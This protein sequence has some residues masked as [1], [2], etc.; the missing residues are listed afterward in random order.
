MAPI[1]F[2]SII[3]WFPRRNFGFV[4]FDIP[5]TALPDELFVHSSDDPNQTLA[6]DV[7]VSFQI[8]QFGGRHKAI[9]VRCDVGYTVS[10]PA[11]SR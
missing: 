9:N 5:L 7:R 4:K 3:S 2:G 1:Y 8:G 6:K 11:V 10:D